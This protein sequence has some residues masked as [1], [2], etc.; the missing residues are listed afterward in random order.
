M[1]P[2]NDPAQPWLRV[3]SAA[4]AGAVQQACLDLLDGKV[5]AREGL[6][7]SL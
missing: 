3:R 2:V 6:M 4:G 1:Q 7:L 5:D